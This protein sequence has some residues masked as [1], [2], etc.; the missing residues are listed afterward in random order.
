[1]ATTVDSM[2]ANVYVNQGILELELNSTLGDS[3]KTATVDGSLA[4][5]G[6]LNSG[7]CSFTTWPRSAKQDYR[8]PKRRLP[9][10]QKQQPLYRQH[11]LRPCHIADSGGI[12]NA[13]GAR[14]DIA[15]ANPNTTMTFNG[16]I[17][18]VSGGTSAAIL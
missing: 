12:L 10:R 5:P 4:V 9:I 17:Q 2:L 13:G 16:A 6:T 7:L 1:M 3:T 18:N 14:S 15:T 8:A 11:S